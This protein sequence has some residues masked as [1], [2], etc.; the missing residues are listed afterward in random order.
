[1]EKVYNLGAWFM[2]LVTLIDGAIPTEK[3]QQNLSMSWI[4]TYVH[5]V[6]VNV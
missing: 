1:M 4:Q 2:L 6:T 3:I 5:S